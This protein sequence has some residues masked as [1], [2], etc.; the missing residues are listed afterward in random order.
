MKIDGEDFKI[1]LLDTHVSVLE[2]IAVKKKIL[3]IYLELSTKIDSSFVISSDV[4]ILTK[5]IM[6][7]FINQKSFNFPNEITT[8]LSRREA[9]EIFIMYHSIL[10]KHPDYIFLIKNITI[11]D[12]ETIWNERKSWLQKKEI[13]FK[14]LE[15][16]V[17]KDVEK[18]KNFEK[19][20]PI[21][22]IDYQ[23]I[24]TRF[25]IIFNSDMSL[26]EIFNSIVTSHTVPYVNFGKFYKIVHNFQ[27][28]PLWLDL[29]TDEVILLKIDCDIGF[30]LED[31]VEEHSKWLK[32]LNPICLNNEIS[33]SSEIS[34][35]FFKRYTNVAI[36]KTTYLEKDVIMATLD[37][38]VGIKNVSRQVFIER[39]YSAITCLSQNDEIK[40]EEKNSV[41]NVIYPNQTLSVPVWAD[42]CM[43]NSIFY[44]ILAIDESIR[45]SKT[46]QNLY[47]HVLD[48]SDTISMMM[49]ETEK[50]FLFGMEE[51][52]TKYTRIKIKTK[53]FLEALRY[54]KIIGIL[55]T[56]YNS[57]INSIFEIYKKYIPVFVSEEEAKILQRKRNNDKLNLRAIAPDIFLATYSRKC[58]KRPTIISDKEAEKLIKKNEKLVMPFPIFGESIKRNYICE[59]KTHPFPG[60]RENHL[61]NKKKFPLVPCCYIKN[62][63]RE[64]TKLRHYYNQ[65]PIKD[66]QTTVQD[67]FLSGK[68][69]PVGMS[70]ILPENLKELFSISD[71]N[72][73]HQFFRL[74]I[75]SKNSFM[76]AVMM[77]LN[78]K[79]LQHINSNSREVIVEKQMSVLKKNA[80]L[81]AM[82]SKQELFNYS[83]ETIVNK[84]EQCNL[85]AKEFVHTL[86]QFF[87]CNIFVF[88]YSKKE[89]NGT[90][91]IPHHSKMYLKN[92]T[93]RKTIFIFE[94]L[95]MN[96]THCEL[97]VQGLVNKPKTLEYLNTV[98]SKEDDVVKNIWKVFETLNLSFN[99]NKKVP[100]IQIPLIKGSSHGIDPQEKILVIS[101]SLDKH[102]KARIVNI[103]F[104]NNLMTFISDPI[105]PFSALE[106][107][108]VYRSSIK[109]I[110]E[111][112]KL[113]NAKIL[114]QRISKDL[115][116]E[117]VVKINQ[118]EFVFLCNDKNKIENIP[119]TF[120]TMEFENLFT[121]IKTPLMLF[122][123][124]KKI[125][126]LLFQKS[127][128]LFSEFLHKN[129]DED[130]NDLLLSQWAQAH[131]IIDPSLMNRLEK[132]NLSENNQ[133]EKY[134]TFS[135][136]NFDHF[137]IQKTKTFSNLI[138]PS[139]EALL[140][141]VFM[142]RLYMNGHIEKIKKYF[143]KTYID[144]FYEE[145]E[146]FFSY[147]NQFV[148]DNLEVVEGL[149][150]TYKTDNFVT[151][152][153]RFESK[154]PYFIQTS[155][156]PN[157][158]F[159]A[160]NILTKIQN[161]QDFRG[162]PK[163]RSKKINK[164]NKLEIKNKKESENEES[165]N[166]E[167]ENEESE[168]E[169]DGDE[170][171]DE[172]EENEDEDK[173]FEMFIEKYKPL[174]IAIFIVRFWDMFQF[175]PT[176]EELS[177]EIEKG[178]LNQ[179][180]VD[181]FNW[182]SSQ[183][184]INLTKYSNPISTGMIFL[185]KIEGNIRYTSVLKI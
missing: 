3:P 159:V 76:E 130:P 71:S 94:H 146:D 97:I 170:E 115:I 59:H 162:R 157:Q 5:N 47:F 128:F 29:I 56:I 16:K 12:L 167:S 182:K 88:S 179:G 13:E 134:K 125:A 25:N 113:L 46:R 105:P 116:R 58:L 37:M 9:E 53:T 43:T 34:K 14:N 91:V 169:Y 153:L 93:N 30:S 18:F 2:R 155:I 67:V 35:R 124:N 142:I 112:C 108:K 85:G 65:T 101:Q 31:N 24:S 27:I 107:N 131:I 95:Q 4:N 87:D 148:F 17:L 180:D 10:R 114:E 138:V 69:L 6:E 158:I 70:G 60:L 149:L 143:L 21:P 185:Y 102:G 123:Y 161:R 175:N 33:D 48:S 40:T 100:M 36:A 171:D 81:Y 51:E 50:A 86:E 120:D 160:R 181:I 15:E 63:D 89:P 38:N 66:Q 165:E 109:I 77:A 103:N 127:L 52:G 152:N 150:E 28:N 55:T 42:L 126:K 62:Q 110:L 64:G 151:K 166:E 117:V 74:G 82:A 1:Y 19:I 144:N 7:P 173:N 137:F 44:N 61:E 8:N 83:I 41:G 140:R 78:N 121:K 177:L 92:F 54:Q 139:K 141:I 20:E 164:L 39:F 84:I 163:K 119:E 147:P 133:L 22:S 135:R 75:N 104:K 96:E 45:A 145:S 98:F 174:N 80:K 68:I 136:F 11:Q 178:S 73:K 118:T 122:D 168:N 90:L 57:E 72:P 183:E 23:E 154:E 184:I 32:N 129:N 176:K 49:K 106:A 132:E 111:L 26:S 79:Q 156:F 99:H 172:D